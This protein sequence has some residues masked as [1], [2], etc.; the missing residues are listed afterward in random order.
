MRQRVQPQFTINLKKDCKSCWDGVDE[1]VELEAGSGN[2]QGLFKLMNDQSWWRT[3][4][5]ETM[6]DGICEPI[7]S[8]DQRLNRRTG[9]FK[10]QFRQSNANLFE[11]TSMAMNHR[12]VRHDLGM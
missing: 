11:P 6:Q 7:H 10:D 2:N 9:Q 4:V 3:S 5:N 12:E 8:K 1:E